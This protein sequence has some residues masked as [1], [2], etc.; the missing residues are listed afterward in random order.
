M[1]LPYKPF[2]AKQYQQGLNVWV[3]RTDRPASKR[4]ANVKDSGRLLPGHGG[5]LDRIDALLAV[6]PVTMALVS[7]IQSGVL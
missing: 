1:V 4:L 5:V 7:L 6:F 3:I 2:L